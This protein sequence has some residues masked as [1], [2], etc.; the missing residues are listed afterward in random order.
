[1]LFLKKIKSKKVK[2]WKLNRPTLLRVESKYELV[3]YLVNFCHLPFCKISTK[4]AC[5]T[6]LLYGP[7]LLQCCSE[8]HTDPCWLLAEL[9]ARTTHFMAKKKFYAHIFVHSS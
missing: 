9:Q 4:C 6:N 1:M 5:W 8:R 7:E 3:S 2:S